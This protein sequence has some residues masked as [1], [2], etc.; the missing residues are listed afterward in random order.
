MKNLNR[1]NHVIEHMKAQELSQIIVTSTPSIFYLTGLWIEPHERM[2][3][4]YLDI[5]GRLVLCGNRLFAID[6]N[7]V[8]FDLLLHSDT[9]NPISDLAGVVK[10]GVIGIDKQWQAN[11]LLPL[12]EM[13]SDVAPKLG[14]SP[15]DLARMIKDTQE[16]ENM[17][18]ASRVNDAAMAAVIAQLKE[19]CSETQLASF[20]QETYVLLGA[21]FPI[22]TQLVC[23]GA[24]AADPHHEPSGSVVKAGDCALFDIFT[25]V[26]RYWCDM[27]RTVYLGDVCKEQEKIYN[28]VKSANAAA[29]QKIAPGVPMAEIDKTARD[30]ITDAGYGEN[31]FHR[32]GHGCGIDCHEP[33]NCNSSST[34]VAHEG[35]IFSVEPGIYI[36]GKYGVRIEDLVLV[37][38]DGC[39]VLN[40]YSKDLQIV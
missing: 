33:P 16:I 18:H 13:R 28:L 22:G 20:L 11:F 19:G 25:P 24:N 15:V 34:A 30:I 3:A 14:S 7:A 39:E 23:F 21:D 27:T 31:F 1:I 37:T 8:D 36:E 4:L 26:N 17:R 2:L 35:M 9:D 32:L 6:E 38:K 12:L 5:N 10:S 29:I 40:K